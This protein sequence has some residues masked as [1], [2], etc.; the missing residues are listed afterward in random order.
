LAFC[1]NLIH[2]EFESL[3][4]KEHSSIILQNAA[5]YTVGHEE[6]EG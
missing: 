4:S 5:V 3:E 6:A 2:L 1:Q